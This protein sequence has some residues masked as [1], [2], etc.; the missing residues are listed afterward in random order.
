M[1]KP[2]SSIPVALGLMSFMFLLIGT[3]ASFN[4]VLKPFL[5]RLF[6][7]N[8]GQSAWIH[9][10]FYAAYFFMA[11]PVSMISSKLGYR[12]TILLGLSVMTLGGVLGLVAGYVGTYPL[13]VLAVFSIAI[14][15]AI[16][17]VMINPYVSR[18]GSE[19]N[20][21]SRLNLVNSFYSTGGIIGPLLGSFLLYMGMEN[22]QLI[23]SLSHPVYLGLIVVLAF[24]ILAFLIIRI[25]ELPIASNRISIQS[26]LELTGKHRNL[27]WGMVAMFVYVGIE[28]GTGSMIA[29]YLVQDHIWGIPEEEAGRW[30]SVYWGSFMVVRL[31]AAQLGTRISAVQ[32]LRINVIASILL[33]ML[34]IFGKGQLAG[35]AILGLGIGH[36]VMFSSIFALGIAGLGERVQE[37]SS[38]IF[39][40]VIGGALLTFLQ[41]NLAD[42]PEI[43][44]NGS[45]FLTFCC[46]IYILWYSFNG[47]RAINSKSQ[48]TT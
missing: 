28:V 22:D 41:N 44:I 26:F 47:Y 19:E 27:K 3:L 14:G 17:V 2:N 34:V 29:K 12:K 5:Q 4:D 6:G 25:P 16:S 20:T 21:N 45:F 15:V 1:S 9:F 23:S 39:M 37:A 48:T 42:I 36:S 8:F 33:V 32:F 30:V 10:S 31:I 7:L 18:I 46:Y 43:G 13:Y 11:V 40:L 35:Y 24:G 38:F